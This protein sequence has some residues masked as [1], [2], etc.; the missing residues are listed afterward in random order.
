[1]APLLA[2]EV[3]LEVAP[4]LLLALV[5]LLLL[6]HAAIV[7][8]AATAIA[9]KAGFLEPRM[10]SSPDDAGGLKISGYADGAGLLDMPR[11]ADAHS[12]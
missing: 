4:P 6:L 2:L 1:L 9:M 8:A 10:G 7:I 11:A 12:G 3:A 5:V